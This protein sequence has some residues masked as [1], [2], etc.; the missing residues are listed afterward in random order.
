VN[1]WIE[2]ILVTIG[3]NGE[4]NMVIHFW[5]GRETISSVRL[6]HRFGQSIIQ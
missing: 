1:V 4:L 3:S 5:A 2:F 6:R